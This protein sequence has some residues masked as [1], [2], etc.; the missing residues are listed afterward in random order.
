MAEHRREGD[1]R[2]GGVDDEVPI[3]PSASDVLPGLASI[4]GLVDA[5]PGGDVAADIPR[6]RRRR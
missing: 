4:P 3:C 1:I 6:R 5:V 2:I